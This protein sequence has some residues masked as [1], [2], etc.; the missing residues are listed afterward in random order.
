MT[1]VVGH[2][3]FPCAIATPD[4]QVSVGFPLEAEPC[5]C[6]HP[7]FPDPA[8][9]CARCGRFSEFTIR[10]TWREQAERIAKFRRVA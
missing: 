10:A 1:V 8:D 3:P 5:R 7:L 6:D 9:T 2:L 4:R